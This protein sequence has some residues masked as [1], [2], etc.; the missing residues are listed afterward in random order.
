[1]PLLST[2]LDLLSFE[3]KEMLQIVAKDFRNPRNITHEERKYENNR[4]NYNENW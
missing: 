2:F 3:R 1:M 4:S